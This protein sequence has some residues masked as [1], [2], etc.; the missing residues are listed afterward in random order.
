[1]ASQFVGSKVQQVVRRISNRLSPQHHRAEEKMGNAA[2]IEATE[3]E[4]PT[5]LLQVDNQEH[6]VCDDDAKQPRRLSLRSVSSKATAGPVR[7][8]SFVASKIGNAI[9]HLFYVEENR[10]ASSAAPPASSNINIRT[11]TVQG[12]VLLDGCDT[13]EEHFER[14][15]AILAVIKELNLK[16]EHGLRA[17]GL[18]MRL[19][20]CV[21]HAAQP[22]KP[23]L[24]KPPLPPLE[25]DT[26]EHDDSS[27]SD[28]ESSLAESN[29]VV[30][31]STEEEQQLD[32]CC[33][34]CVT[35]LFHHQTNTLIGH[36]N[37]RS[38]ISD[39][40]MYDE[41]S[42]FCMEYA[43]EI[44]IREG[45]LQ[46]VQIEDDIQALVS[47]T[48]PAATTGSDDADDDMTS[49]KKPTLL[50]VT[51]KGK[52]RA[53]IFS[54]Q[55]IQTTGLEPSTA[56]FVIR[57]AKKR[58]MNIIMLDPNCRGEREAY[59]VVQ[60]SMQKLFG[61]III[62]QQQQENGGQQQYPLFIQLHSAAGSHVVRYLI[63]YWDSFLPHIR[64]MA[65]TDSTHNIQWTKKTMRLFEFLESPAVVYFRSTKGDTPHPAGLEINSRDESW[66]RRFGTIRTCWAGTTEHSLSDWHARDFIWQHFD[67]HMIMP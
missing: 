12:G 50:I 30:E 44:M 29:H 38:F 17:A 34:D 2:C 22:V 67:R 59:A 36:L 1:M 9:D 37:R 19:V 61:H 25:E 54:R 58:N 41:V 65:F 47:R 8:V 60:K 13:P 11:R 14:H 27:V 52:V 10:H 39:G 32:C 42:R 64:A 6:S 16:G 7:F 5:M 53:G 23:P 55:H 43:Q 20:C 33:P 21:K 56:L 49:N 31:S 48:H 40:E 66:K 3:D 24:E 35:R 51:G 63:D 18:E 46:W 15:D 62:D 4:K 45:D 57:E 28:I 26:P